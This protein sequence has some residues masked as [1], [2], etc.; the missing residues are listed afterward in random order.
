MFKVPGHSVRASLAAALFAFLVSTLSLAQVAVTTYHNDTYRSG[1]NTAETT[2]NQANVNQQTFGKRLTLPVQGYV[3]AQ[4]LYVPNLNIGGKSHNVVFIATE[5]LQVYAFDADTGQQLWHNNYMGNF[6]VTS[7]LPVNSADVSCTDLIPEIGIT[8]TP[9]I[10]LNTNTMYLVTKQ[11][12]LQKLIQKVSYQQVVHALDITTGRDK[13]SHSITAKVPGTGKGSNGGYLTFDPLV[14]SQRPALLLENGEVF[15]SFASHCDLFNYHGYLM[16]FDKTSLA[17]TGVHVTTPDGEDGGYWASGAG[18]AADSTGDIYFASGNG[19]YTGNQ[20]GK[21]LGDSVIRFHWSNNTIAPVDY[22]TPWDYAKLDQYDTDLGS[23]GVLLLPDQPGAP[24]PHLLVQVGKEG[25]IDL[26][27]RD[28][29][30]HWH[31]GNDSQIVQTLPFQM[32]E[33]FGS[34]AFWNNYVYFGPTYGKM[35]AFSYDPVAQRL[36]SSFTSRSNEVFSFPGPVPSVSSNGALDGIVWIIESDTVGSG[37]GI[38]R[39]YNAS[40]LSKELYNSQQNSA[41]DHAGPA[42]KFTVPTIADGHVFVGSVDEVDV[43]GLLN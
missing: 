26:I 10:D 9:V 3:Y 4:P 27:N 42:V 16:S 23:G 15:I 30:G 38:L 21:D 28:N 2:L 8:G 40:D 14:Q 6:S 37:N 34:P 5:H 13:I 1:A 31:N 36:S 12:L 22:F 39:A 43:Y 11:K 7:T 19:D 25:T 33:L 29:M 18:P 20:G 24:I 35:Q 17:P 41:R 32:N